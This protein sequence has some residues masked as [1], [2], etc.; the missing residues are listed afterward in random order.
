MALRARAGGVQRI[1]LTHSGHLSTSEAAAAANA[2]SFVPSGRFVLVGQ[3][4][5]L[6][7]DISSLCPS[8]FA[9]LEHLVVVG[10][11]SGFLQL[12]DTR[13]HRGVVLRE[14]KAAKNL[15][16]RGLRWIDPS[17]VIYFMFALPRG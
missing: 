16:I 15:P 17:R 10:T 11:Q 8:P 12:I 2:A 5:A 7:N 9:G 6:A 1:D 13:P 4:A 14:F 3:L